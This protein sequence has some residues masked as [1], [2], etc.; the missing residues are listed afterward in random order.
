MNQNNQN[1]PKDPM[2][3]FRS[4]KRG[5]NSKGGDRTELFMTKEQAEVLITELTKNLDQPH[6]VKLDLHVG[7]R[8]T[9]DGTREFDSAVCFV[10]AVQERPGAGGGAPRN[11]APKGAPSQDTMTNV[12]K[13]KQGLEGV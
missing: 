12:Q 2:V 10:K 8:M 1:R 5:K 11:F 3:L 4:V 6:G 7:K 9:N 13:F